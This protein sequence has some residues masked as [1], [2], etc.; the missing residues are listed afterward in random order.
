MKRHCLIVLAV[1]VALLNVVIG[2]G[3]RPAT[4]ACL[5]GNGTFVSIAVTDIVGPFPV[6]A[7]HSYTLT[8][9]DMT[10]PG[11]NVIIAGP[12]GGWS[13]SSP[14]SSTGIVPWS[15]IYLGDAGGGNLHTIRYTF[16]DNSATCSGGTGAAGYFGPLYWDGRLNDKDGQETSAVYCLGDGSVRVYVIGNPK[17]TIDFDANPTEIAKVPKHPA[18][19]TLIKKGHFAAL[20]RQ[21]NGF[22]LVSSPGLNP[23]DGDYTFIFSDC[24]LPAVQK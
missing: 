20:S 24:T 10:V 6:T 1:L 23:K 2:G 13:G 11:G 17:W 5:V 4:A 19:N 21:T 7:G 14:Q 18:H 12:G 22:L 3:V 9:T 8:V 16:T 15:G